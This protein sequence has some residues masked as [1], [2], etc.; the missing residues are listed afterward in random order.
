[1]W[2][3][4]T[5]RLSTRELAQIFDLERHSPAQV[6]P[7]KSFTWSTE[8]VLNGGDSDDDNGD[9]AVRGA[10]LATGGT[11]GKTATI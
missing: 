2:M 6:S 4:D 8:A 1:M 7:A 9:N 10:K 5:G 11:K 3:T